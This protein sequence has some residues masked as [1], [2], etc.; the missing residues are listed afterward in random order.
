MQVKYIGP[1][2]EVE[3]PSLGVVVKRDGTVDVDDATGAALCEQPRNW[4]A[5]TKPR[6]QKEA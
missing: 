6:E 3:V 5:A 1:F 4:K 2:N